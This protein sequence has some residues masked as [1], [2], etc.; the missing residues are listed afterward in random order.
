MHL[1]AKRERI[2][3]TGHRG[4]LVLAVLQRL[5]H[6][7]YDILHVRTRQELD[8]HDQSTLNRFFD[9][10]PP[11]DV[12]L[13][14]AR[15]DSILANDTYPTDSIGGNLAM[16]TCVLQAAQRTGVKLLLFLSSM[17]AYAREAP[18]PL[19]EDHLCTWPGEPT[20][21]TPWQRSKAQSIAKQC[22]SNKDAISCC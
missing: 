3:V 7:G 12:V 22:E 8:L 21:S 10:V 14:A 15:V 1:S 17:C 9:A 6:D 4:L 11:E 13:A 18:Q 5:T 20:T 16:R 2:F 19:K